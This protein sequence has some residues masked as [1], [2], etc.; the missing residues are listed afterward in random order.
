MV[1]KQSAYVKIYNG[2]TKWMYFS[3]MNY[4]KVIKV[5]GIK[6]VIVLRT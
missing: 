6:S 3:M 1:P 5:F 4:Q 2:E